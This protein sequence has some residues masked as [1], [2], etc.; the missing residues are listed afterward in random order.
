ML[1]DNIVGRKN[2]EDKYL[3]SKCQVHLKKIVYLFLTESFLNEELFF[4]DLAWFHPFYDVFFTIHRFDD[5]SFRL[6]A[7]LLS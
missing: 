6:V 1:E 3:C 4:L 7:E 5:Y 2:I